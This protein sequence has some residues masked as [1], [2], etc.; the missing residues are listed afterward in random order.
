MV[1]IL[2]VDDEDAVRTVVVRLLDRQ[3]YRVLEADSGEAALNAAAMSET[4][5]DVLVTDVGMS[6]MEGPDLARELRGK[7][8]G[9][10]VIYMSGRLDDP[11][12]APDCLLQ[13]EMFLPKP[14]RPEALVEAVRRMIES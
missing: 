10:K 11:R 2:V 12:V 14:F 7:Y 4:P 5:P 13:G 8:P 3:H 9:V 6:P 1:T